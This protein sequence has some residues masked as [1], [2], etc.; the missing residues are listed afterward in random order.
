MPSCTHVLV[1]FKKLLHTAFCVTRAPRGFQEASS[2]SCGVDMSPL[3][4]RR[5]G[6]VPLL[7]LQRPLE[8]QIISDESP[9][10]PESKV[11]KRAASPSTTCPPSCAVSDSGATAFDQS[12]DDEHN[13]NTKATP[14]QPTPPDEQATPPTVEV[15]STPPQATSTCEA[16]RELSSNENSQASTTLDQHNTENKSARDIEAELAFVYKTEQI[17]EDKDN[18]VD[19]DPLVQALRKALNEGFDIRG[20]LG[21]K[22]QR[23]HR[24]GSKNYDA[25]HADKSLAAKRRFR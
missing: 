24:K 14:A 5:K 22:F 13:E 25:Y 17:G 11:G 20:S 23:A 12:S 8:P 7:L 4:S 16:V 15:M 6:V 19:L 3:R 9:R 18:A 21:Q 2:H 10:T 1:R